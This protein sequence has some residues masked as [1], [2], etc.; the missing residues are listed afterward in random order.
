M[1]HSCQYVL[2]YGDGA[3]YEY[4]GEDCSEQSEY[5]Y[6]HQTAIDFE[7]Y[8]YDEPDDDE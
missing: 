4:C 8:Y 3:T 2:S 1:P 7:K 6:E 5:C